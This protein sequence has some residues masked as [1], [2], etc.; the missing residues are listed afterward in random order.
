MQP[1]WESLH[2]LLWWPPRLLFW[3]VRPLIWC[4]QSFYGDIHVGIT[5]T[6]GEGGIAWWKETQDA[7]TGSGCAKAI[8]QPVWC[9]ELVLARGECCA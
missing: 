3:H 1:L 2:G 7:G 5:L 9:P 4:E 6:T 8:M